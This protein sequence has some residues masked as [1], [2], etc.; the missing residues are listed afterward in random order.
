MSVSSYL[1]SLPSTGMVYFCRD[2]Q[3]IACSTVEKLISRQ[4]FAR[5][6]FSDT[7]D[8]VQDANGCTTK[9]HK[10]NPLIHKSSYN[11]G[12]YSAEGAAEVFRMYNQTFSQYLTATAGRRFDPPIHFEIV[13]VGY[14]S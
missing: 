11:V 7:Y 4:S 3:G 10:F 1:P 6:P 8:V 9:I 13:P 12:I 14:V 2:S 5:F